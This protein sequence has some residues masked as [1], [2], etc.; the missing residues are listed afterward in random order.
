LVN[1][2]E[3]PE[4]VWQ[5]IM[6]HFAVDCSEADRTLMADAARFDAKAPGSRFEPDADTKQREAGVQIRSAAQ[7]WSN[8]LYLRLEARRAGVA[9]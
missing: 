6:P 4:A 1:Y 5:T 3:L 7:T 9:K 8:D 2:S